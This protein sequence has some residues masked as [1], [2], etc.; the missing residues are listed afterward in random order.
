MRACICVYLSLVSS[1][2]TLLLLAARVG[3]CIV[4]ICAPL[5]PACDGISSELEQ[6][7]VHLREQSKDPLLYSVSS[8]LYAIMEMHATHPTSEDRATPCLNLM[9]VSVL[10]GWVLKGLVQL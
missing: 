2:C 4:D 1:F 3:T 10:Q 6:V 5:S 8:G 7:Q 9:Q